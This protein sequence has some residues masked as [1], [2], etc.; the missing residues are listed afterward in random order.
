MERMICSQCERKKLRPSMLIYKEAPG[1]EQV[2]WCSFCHEMR[3]C[4]CLKIR[5][6][7]KISE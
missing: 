4:K 7:G 2:T 6:G 3:Y 1:R 5:I